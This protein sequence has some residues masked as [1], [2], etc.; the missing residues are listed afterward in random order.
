[1]KN[2]DTLITILGIILMIIV[3]MFSLSISQER[4]RPSSCPEAD[5]YT[6]IWP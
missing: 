1:M 3:I 2:N 4:E 5:C 6:E